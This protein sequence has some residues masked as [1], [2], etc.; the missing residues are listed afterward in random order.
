MSRLYWGDK[1]YKIRQ[2]SR[3]LVCY[4]SNGLGSGKDYHQKCSLKIFGSMEPPELVYHLNDMKA[5]AKKIIQS[6]GVIT[7]VQPKI[8]LGIKKAKRERGRLTLMIGDYILKPPSEYFAQMPE[9]E[10]LTMHLAEICEIQT[11]PHAL[12]PLASGELSY[13]TKR[14]DREYDSKIHMEDFCQ[15]SELLTENKYNSSMERVGKI[16]KKFSAYPGLDLINVFEL[17]IFSFIVGNNDMH[18]KN[19]SLID[20]D[21]GWHLSPAYDLLNVNLVNKKDLE[22]TALT[23]N[24]KKRKLN[25]G[26]FLELANAYELNEAQVRN[27]FEKILSKE[28]EMSDFISISFID[29]NYKDQYK[30]ILQSRCEILRKNNDNI[31]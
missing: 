30:Y 7:G 29:D 15:L 5:L 26:D 17:T 11:V 24:G 28:K 27:A 10:D 20:D 31:A 3:C 2:M 8:S 21:R 23:I 4:N 1:S 6:H 16:A 25:L 18:L 9:T 19:F 13:I 22:E 14:V 12:I